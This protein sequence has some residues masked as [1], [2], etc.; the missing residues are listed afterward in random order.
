M[1]KTYFS[2]P[3]SRSAKDTEGR[4]RNIFQGQ[5][6]RPALIVL[7]LVA[8]LALLC[9]S[10]VAVRSRSA[11][12][13]AL[14]TPAADRGQEKSEAAALKEVSEENRELAELPPFVYEGNETYLAAVCQWIVEGA[15]AEYPRAPVTIPC[16]LIVEADDS[17]PQDILIWGNFWVFRY[18]PVGTTLLTVSGGEQPGLLHLRSAD[19][20]CAVYE[21]ERVGDGSQYAEDMKRIFGAGR[22]KALD[23]IDR[24]TVRAQYISD[25]VLQNGLPFTQYQDYGWDPV[26]IP[27]T[28]ETPEAAQHIHYISPMG[29]SI[30]YDLRELVHD[31]DDDRPESM[32]E[33]LTGV[34][35]LNG[36]SICIERYVN[37]DAETVIA[38]REKE[39]ERPRRRETAI[40]AESIPATMI[41]DDSTRAE[42]MKDTYVIALNK[43]DY[44]AVTVRNTFYAV[45]GDPIVQGADEVLNKALLTFR[46]MKTEPLL[47]SGEAGR[48]TVYASDYESFVDPSEAL[49]DWQRELLNHLSAKEFPREAVELSS[50]F[51]RD[52][53][54]D[55]LI[56]LAYDEASDVT[57]YGAVAAQGLEGYGERIGILS[58]ALTDAGIVLRAGDR[59]AYF[60]APWEGNLR[61]GGNPWLAVSDFDGDGADEAAFCLLV[62]T[63][64]GVSCHVLHLVDLD[65]MER[66]TVDITTLDVRFSYDRAAHTVSVF[67]G[68]LMRTTEVPEYFEP[69]DAIICGNVVD[70]KYADGVLSCTMALDY[71]QTIGYFA[72]IEAPVRW[73]G[74][75]YALDEITA[76]RADGYF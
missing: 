16:P 21:A 40:G 29:Y 28:P 30:D 9:G 75:G 7:T 74:S 22:L 32:T 23:A 10:V 20:S 54:R 61:Y 51:R 64:T 47:N 15:G 35:A 31:V 76:L 43:T 24:E 1:P 13:A 42:V 46:L 53:W 66:H 39:M 11:A 14:P 60:P 69:V 62:G 12:G 58:S 8:A 37:T 52:C 33:S 44:L 17:D 57:L 59:A 45:S 73:N 6:K 18:K 38:E 68:G 65:T 56:P 49:N 72:D 36:I 48:V 63:G 55:T 19:G 41:R 25:Y 2:A 27:G 67:G 70:Y 26:H 34:G 50:F 71:G 4:V 3:L 5:R